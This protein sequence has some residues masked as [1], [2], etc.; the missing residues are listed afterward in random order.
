MT[1]HRR[2]VVREELIRSIAWLALGLVGW[3]ILVEELAALEAS[4]LT[5]G[6]LPVLTWAGLTLGMIGLRFLTDSATQVETPSGL[7]ISLVLGITLGGVGA[8]YLVA[9]ENQAALWVTAAYVGVSIAA[10]A[11][12]WYARVPDSPADPLA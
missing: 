10:V 8:V 2:E 12:H 4:L 7:S 3:A 11:W 1:L 5:V 6:V 9:V